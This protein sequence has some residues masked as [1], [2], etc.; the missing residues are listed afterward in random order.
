MNPIRRLF[1]IIPLFILPFVGRAT[2]IEYQADMSGVWEVPPNA[3]S[4]SGWTSLVYDP[5]AHTLS[6]EVDFEGLSVPAFGAHIHAPAMRNETAGIAI[7][8][9]G[10][11]MA[12]EGSYSQSFDL[13]LSSVFHPAFLAVHGGTAAGAE[14][15][16]AAY[17]AQGLAYLNIHTST[18]PG[19]EI[20]GNLVHVPDLNSTMLL[21]A[22]FAL[23]LLGFARR[24]LS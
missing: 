9:P 21:V 4:A 23:C 1:A 20:R 13:T 24:R 19:G 15:A 17:L 3:S 10:F 16:V 6:V 2:P 18:F 12:V 22:P 7:G 11:P 14:A 5:E 8:L